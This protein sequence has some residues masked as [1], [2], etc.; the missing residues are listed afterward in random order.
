MEPGLLPTYLYPAPSS[1]KGDLGKKGGHP[2]P[3]GEQREDKEYFLN[4]RPFVTMLRLTR[5][6]RI[7][8]GYSDAYAE[9]TLLQLHPGSSSPLVLV[10]WCVYVCPLICMHHQQKRNNPRPLLL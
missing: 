9:S 1:H 7:V 3:L 2:N 6:N 4:M 10:G 8:R 5:V